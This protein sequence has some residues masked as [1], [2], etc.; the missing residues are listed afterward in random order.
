MRTR[1]RAALLCVTLLAALPAP[2]ALAQPTPEAKAAAGVAADKGL[3]LYTAGRYEEALAAFEKADQTFHAPTFVLMM[4]RSLA[5]LGRLCEARARYQ[6][7]IDE[8]LAHYAPP[9][10]FKAQ[11]QA[12]EELPP[13]LPRIPTLQVSV[14]GAPASYLRLII[15]GL[16]AAP[17]KA[18]PLDP[19]DHIVT[20]A[21]PGFG[22][23]TRQVTLQEGAHEQVTLDLQALPPEPS[24]RTTTPDA[25]PEEAPPPEPSR[26]YAAPIAA[27]GVAGVALGVGVVTGALSLS[28]GS[29]LK[30]E[31]PGGRCY[32]DAGGDTY[33]GVETLSTVS[34]VS[35]VVGG[36]AAAAGVALLLWPQRSEGAQVGVVVGPGWTG[37]RGAF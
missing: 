9:A 7:V 5:K 21:I 31:C 6:Q 34:N 19:G 3:D 29:E 1:A 28:K 24:A 25:R 37:M 23:E 27:F 16:P 4:A 30:E 12:K 14:T 22:R 20:A 18:L 8:P 11:A 13:L 17:G 33:D 32:N 10:F 15:D 26:S 36:V 2:E 35:F